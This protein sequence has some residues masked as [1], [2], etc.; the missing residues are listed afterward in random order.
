MKRKRGDTRPDGLIYWGQNKRDG[1]LWVGPERYE[2][3]RNAH[4][5]DALARYRSNTEYREKIKEYQK[6]YRRDTKNKIKLTEYFRVLYLKDP[7]RKRAVM[8]RKKA[9]YREDA[10]FAVL[11]KLRARL[12]CAVKKRAKR[13]GL[14]TSSRAADRVSVA[15][16]LWLANKKGVNP[17]DGLKW[18][19]DHLTP[20][21][22]FSG[23]LENVNA[24]ENV[25]WLSARDNA[26]KRDRTP[27]KQEVED[28]LTLVAEWRNSFSREEN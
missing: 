15:F 28:H 23:P 6:S 3:K 11:S 8:A 21:S 18:H 14:A 19:I 16:L 20:V 4:A 24:P 26:E 17:L 27:A 7:N 12:R 1:E 5:K 10:D 9:R 13:L 22:K 25:R 2:E